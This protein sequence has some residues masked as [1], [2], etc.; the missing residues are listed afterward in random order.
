MSLK[1]GYLLV[2]SHNL[3][4]RRQELGF[5]QKQFAKNVG[6][7][8]RLYQ[9]LEAGDGNPTLGS[10]SNISKK[11]NIDLTELLRLRSLRINCPVED[12]LSEF[13]QSFERAQ[14]AVAVRTVDGLILW[15]NTC[16]MQ[17]HGVTPDQY[18]IHANDVLTP[19]AAKIFHEQLMC[20]RL[21]IVHP[22][23][24][25]AKHS[26]G[27]IVHMRY[28][29]TLIYEKQKKTPKCTVVYLSD[30]HSYADEIYYHFSE[31]LIRS[32]SPMLHV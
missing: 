5:S 25:S 21:G 10:L 11:F 3:R 19:E 31:S 12:F 4:S 22:Y 6:L 17:L 16:T 9:R 28:F 32:V 30:V 7:S 20:E 1:P 8:Y 15:A 18:P 14:F 29:P 13:Q 23:V 27:K 24:N 2:L 26:D